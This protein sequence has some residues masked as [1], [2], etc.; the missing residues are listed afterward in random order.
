MFCSINS[1]PQV[2]AGFEPSREI[3]KKVRRRCIREM[4]YESDD[5]VQSLARKFKISMGTESRRD[6]LYNIQFGAD[7]A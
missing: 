3:L 1:T 5:Q 2:I 7:Y 6:L 4:D